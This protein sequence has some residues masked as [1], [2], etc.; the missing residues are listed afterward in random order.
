[1]TPT[2]LL[3]FQPSLSAPIA[4]YSQKELQTP[5]PQ[6]QHPLPQ[7]ALKLMHRAS[8]LHRLLHQGHHLLDLLPDFLP[9]DITIQCFHTLHD[10]LLGSPTVSFPPVVS[11]FPAF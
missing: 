1:M 10:G 11:S 7:S 6:R 8:R 4:R 9:L 3:A 2:P 5:M